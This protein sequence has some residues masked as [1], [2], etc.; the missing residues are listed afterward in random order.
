[1]SR[2]GLRSLV[3]IALVIALWVADMFATYVVF[4]S[5]FPGANDF[6]SR[7]G[8]ARAW[9][10]QGLSPYSEQASIQIEIG[11]YGR[12]A[13]PD[14]DPGPFAYPFYTVFL[15][16]PL[17]FLPYAW[18]EAIWL[19]LLEFALVGSVVGAM[20]LAEWRLP[21]AL[22]AITTIWAI[23]F[24]HSARAILLGQF[25]VVIL[26][27]IVGT[28]L[29]LRARRDAMAGVFLALATIKP[30]MIYLLVPM[31][32]FWAVAR[33]R[34]RLIG[35]FVGAMTLLCGASF[36]A[37]PDWLTSFVTQMMRYP[38]YTAI[39]S[40]VWV[41]THYF[42]PALG[43]PGEIVLSLTLFAWVLVT[44]QRLWRDESR[45]AFLWTVSFTLI[46]TNLIA[47]RTATTNYVVLFIP[48]LQIL[49]AVQT[50]WKRAGMWGV[51]GIEV[52]LLVG[53]WA[54]FLATVANKFEHP[55]MYLPL[56]VGLLIV[57]AHRPLFMEKRE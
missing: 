56:P 28:L 11:I 13:L 40:P 9:W 34:W 52:A 55:I 14:E 10:T 18:A 48:L 15:I 45:P 49:A 47:L 4:T 33:R 54:L 36:V 5:R 57:M 43:A 26:M 17:A 1:M 30:Q 38:N 37:Q 8:G 51:I 21:P 27:F 25:A 50:R 29:A 12:R 19:A 3:L 39:G 6:Y 46:V 31:V 20:A 44:W 16:A 24:Y 53:L 22:M 2:V 35:G 41:I 42:I 23:L 32:L 7:W